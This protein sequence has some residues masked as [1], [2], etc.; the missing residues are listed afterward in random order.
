MTRQIDYVS[1]YLIVRRQEDGTYTKELQNIQGAASDPSPASGASV[2]KGPFIVAG[3]DGFG[4]DGGA[5]LDSFL[6]S[7]LQSSADRAGVQLH[8]DR[9]L[10]RTT[11]EYRIAVDGASFDQAKWIV[12]PD[13]APVQG[14]PVKYWKIVGDTV[15]EMPQSEKD[16]VDASALPGNI[17]SKIGKFKVSVTGYV[18]K[19]YDPSQQMTL[20][21]LWSEALS[22]SWPNR[23]AKIQSVMDWVNA[24]LIYFYQKI[25]EASACTV[26]SALD[27]VAFDLTQFDAT[28]PK[29]SLGD[30]RAA[31]N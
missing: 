22:K 27:A 18:A 7:V 23:S 21:S 29:V 13:M 17:A 5:T 16:G 20:L 15:S 4:Y 24:V 14:I 26:Q 30:V 9:V 3:L 10:N 25:A 6:Q 28:D 8:T 12:N 19:H 11:K 1:V 2:D 31:T